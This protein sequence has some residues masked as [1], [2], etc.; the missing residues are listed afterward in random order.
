[1]KNL[2]IRLSYC[3]VAATAASVS[4]GALPQLGEPTVL[5]AVEVAKGDGGDAVVISL[6]GNGQLSGTLQEIDGT[7]FR[8]FVDLKEVVPGVSAVTPVAL[9]N[10]ERIRVA[11]NQSHPP[12]TRVVL[13]LSSR[14]PYRLEEASETDGLRIVIGTI[15]TIDTTVTAGAPD[16]SGTAGTSA[17]DVPAVPDHPKPTYAAWFAHTS[18]RVDHHLDTVLDDNDVVVW[19]VLAA[20]VDAHAAPPAF[21]VA[22]DLLK[23]VVRLGAVAVRNEQP[24][25]STDSMDRSTAV[26]GARLLL[27]RARMIVEGQSGP[28]TKTP[29]V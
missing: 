18:E 26:A 3:I 22:H 29:G 11:L 23:T 6:R 19:H 10:V 9:G 2:A 12:V 8:V 7:P 16:S 28:P 27:S 14:Q 17:T 20:E 5:Q 1:M 25:P 13:D 24:P 15:G 21:A 4:V